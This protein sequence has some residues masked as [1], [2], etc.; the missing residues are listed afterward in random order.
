MKYTISEDL[1]HTIHGIKLCAEK[2]SGE[3]Y[4]NI[5]IK[6]SCSEDLG[7]DSLNQVEFIMELEKY[8]NIIIND[9]Q[10]E[11]IVTLK[12]AVEWVNKLKE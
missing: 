8:F 5:K 12:D 9:D 7:L 11:N 3:D 10:S 1:R 6:D 4:K 2:I